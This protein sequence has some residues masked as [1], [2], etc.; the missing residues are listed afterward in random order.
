MKFFIASNLAA[1]TLCAV[2]IGLRA[3]AAPIPDFTGYKLELTCSNSHGKNSNGDPCIAVGTGP[4]GSTVAWTYGAGKCDMV[5][6]TPSGDNFCHIPF[7]LAAYNKKN[8]TIEGCGA[9][10]WATHNGK[11][12]GNC[13]T[14]GPRGAKAECGL[15]IEYICG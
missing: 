10:L 6:L 2:L 5:A 4:E 3:G 15:N 9:P 1:I 14:Q 11:L 8:L 7:S 13:Q 12:L